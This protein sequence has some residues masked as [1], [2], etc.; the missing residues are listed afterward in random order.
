LYRERETGAG[1]NADKIGQSRVPLNGKFYIRGRNR[2]VFTTVNICGFDQ[3]QKAGK[4]V[5]KCDANISEK[6]TA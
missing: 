2:A 3:L 1:T 6:P 4:P 5:R